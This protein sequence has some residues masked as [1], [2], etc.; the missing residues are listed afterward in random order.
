MIDGGMIDDDGHENDCW[1]S[2]GQALSSERYE[3]IFDTQYL[4]VLLSGGGRLLK[5][6]DTGANMEVVKVQKK[7]KLVSID[8]IQSPLSIM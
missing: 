1:N 6:L 3:F 8:H 5:P 4:C 2:G 7:L